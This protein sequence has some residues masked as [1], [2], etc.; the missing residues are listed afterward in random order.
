MG[1][2]IDRKKVIF[3]VKCKI[4]RQKIDCLEA[5]SA[6]CFSQ[7]RISREFVV[8]PRISALTTAHGG[9]SISARSASS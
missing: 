2:K 1:Q 4:V 7:G 9:I 6:A 5:A 3:C 8:H